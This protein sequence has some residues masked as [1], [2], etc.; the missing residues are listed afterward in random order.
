[1][2]TLEELVPSDE[3][4]LTANRLCQARL[5]FQAR[6]AVW[7]RSHSGAVAGREQ[8]TGCREQQDWRRS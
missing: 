5:A 1:M 7:D 8:A 6:F 2:V 4:S 3:R